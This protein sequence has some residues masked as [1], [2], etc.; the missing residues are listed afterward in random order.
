[1]TNYKISAEIRCLNV[2]LDVAL[3][4]FVVAICSHFLIC[5]MT[6]QYFVVRCVCL[7]MCVEFV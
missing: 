7:C 4:L 5:L 2:C 1:M 6:F 3:L